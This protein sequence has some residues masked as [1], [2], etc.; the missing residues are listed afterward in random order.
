[1]M[2]MNVEL[3]HNAWRCSQALVAHFA[4]VLTL[5]LRTAH[6]AVATGRAPR[7]SDA[8][9]TFVRCIRISSAL[10][11]SCLVRYVASARLLATWNRALCAQSRR[12]RRAASRHRSIRS[13][14]ALT[15]GPSRYARGPV[16]H[17]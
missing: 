12:L 6:G 15:P 10:L 9:T 3:T 17:F 7:H 4:R 14:P 16:C 1:M 2:L 5:V 11:V 8:A 13:E